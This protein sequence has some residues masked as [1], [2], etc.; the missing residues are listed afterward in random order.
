MKHDEYKQDISQLLETAYEYQ[1][2]SWNDGLIYKDFITALWRT[3]LKH[4]AFKEKAKSMQSAIGEGKCL[5]LIAAQIDLTR[6]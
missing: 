6:K 4:E 3:F 2:I 1:L 5:E